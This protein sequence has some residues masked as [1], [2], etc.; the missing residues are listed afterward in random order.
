[1]P[2]CVLESQ[3]KAFAG[4]G[5]LWVY[6]P[7]SPQCCHQLPAGFGA[8]SLLTRCV[9][10][11]QVCSAVMCDSCHCQGCIKAKSSQLESLNSCL[12]QCLWPGWPCPVPCKPSLQACCSVAFSHAWQGCSSPALGVYV[13]RDI[14]VGVVPGCSN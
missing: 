3:T 12:A 4:W 13:L 7:L 5:A 8:T 11:V 6:F 14:P 2:G 9:N 10:R 1:M